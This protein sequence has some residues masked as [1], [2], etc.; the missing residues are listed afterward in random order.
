MNRIDSIEGWYNAKQTNDVVFP[1]SKCTN[2]C[3]GK[4]GFCCAH[5]KARRDDTKDII[6]DGPMG[7]PL[8]VIT[9][10]WNS[11]TRLEEWENK[12]GATLSRGYR[13][14]SFTY[15]KHHNHQASAHAVE[16]GNNHGKELFGFNVW[17]FVAGYGGKVYR[18]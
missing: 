3:T 15:G 5:Q 1:T 12:E 18:Y 2:E 14:V 7:R 8:L 9:T 13:N 16:V 6:I 17:C 11:H 10:S 4:F